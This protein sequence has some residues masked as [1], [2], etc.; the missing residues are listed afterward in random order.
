MDG[1][2]PTHAVTDSQG[3]RVH[4]TASGPSLYAT[5]TSNSYF[6]IL[7]FDFPLSLWPAPVSLASP[8]TL[9]EPV[10][11]IRDVLCKVGLK[12]SLVRLGGLTAELGCAFQG[13]GNCPDLDS[14]T[15][16]RRPLESRNAASAASSRTLTR[17]GCHRNA[18]GP[19][20]VEPAGGG[21]Q[22]TNRPVPAKPS[23][24]HALLSAKIKVEVHSLCM[25]SHGLSDA[26]P[27]QQQMATRHACYAWNNSSASGLGEL[28]RGPSSVA[29][30]MS[31]CEWRDGWAMVG[32][33]AP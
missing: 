23:R 25:E 33:Q 2:K 16:T 15:L 13:T 32:R 7:S 18:E 21:R 10:G 1:R 24:S 11:G 5:S 22:Q 27:D 9:R 3:R 19:R 4:S 8:A 29:C 30:P 20:S 12:P 31:L 14:S 26:W 6:T 17:A 28:I